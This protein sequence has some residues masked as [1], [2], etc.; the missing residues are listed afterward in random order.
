MAEN[1]L[2]TG[3]SGLVGSRFVELYQGPNPLLAPDLPEFNLTDRETTARCLLT[4]RP[5][6][7]VHFAA[8]TDVSAA[9]KQKG[10]KKGLCWQVNVVGTRN[11]LSAAKKIGAKVYYISTDMVFSGQKEDPG[12]Y[13]ENHPPPTH[14]NKLTWYGYTKATAERLLP[15]ESAIIRII[16]PV[17]AKFSPKL[18]YLRKPLKLFDEGRLYPLFTNQQVSI[19]FVDEICTA[20]YKI[21]SENL[22]GVFH[23]GSV[24]TSSP[25]DLITYLLNKTRGKTGVVTPAL[26]TDPVRYPQFGG[27]Q[28]RETERKLGMKFST[29]RQ[30]ID[31]LVRQGIRV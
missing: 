11:L 23:I 6:V 9:E 31:Q 17:R 30:I 1:I 12:P 14:P 15:S 21:I 20:L 5:R 3:S 29:C 10:D 4:L 28:V 26:L 16:Y 2:V 22:T 7:V 13:P 24:D 8:Y 19:S 18:D 25:F 27:L